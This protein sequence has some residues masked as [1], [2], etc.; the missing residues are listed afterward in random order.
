MKRNHGIPTLGSCLDK[1]VTHGDQRGKGK[2]VQGAIV[3]FIYSRMMG[4]YCYCLQV[5]EV[6]RLTF[7]PM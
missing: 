2:R 3:A 1:G 4:L 7:Y 6:L 5:F